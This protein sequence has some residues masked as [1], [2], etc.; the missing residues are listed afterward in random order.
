MQE[1]VCCLIKGREKKKKRRQ[2]CEWLS[3]AVVH[4]PAAVSLLLLEALFMQISGVS[5]T[6]T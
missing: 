4:L 3:E 6:L 5:L 2:F 1:F